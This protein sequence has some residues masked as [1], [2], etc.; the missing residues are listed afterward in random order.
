[1]LVC[2]LTRFRCLTYEGAAIGEV[3]SIFVRII[4]IGYYYKT[5]EFGGKQW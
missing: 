5:L 4:I 3:P 2:F 1:M